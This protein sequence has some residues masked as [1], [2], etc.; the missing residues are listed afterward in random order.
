MNKMHSAPMH[1]HLAV[2]CHKFNNCVFNFASTKQK[3]EFVQQ[4]NET[5]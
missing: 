4:M 5:N 2:T 1:S 3:R